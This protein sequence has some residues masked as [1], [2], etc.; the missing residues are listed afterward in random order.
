[1]ND[2]SHRETVMVDDWMFLSG[3]TDS[4]AQVVINTRFLI[5]LGYREAKAL[6][7]ALQHTHGPFI[8]NGYHLT[9]DEVFA[10][11]EW[12]SAIIDDEYGDEANHARLPHFIGC[13]P[14]RLS[15]RFRTPMDQRQFT[16]TFQHSPSV[17]AVIHGTP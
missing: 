17:L 1:M 4:T 13:E 11:H 8:L 10:L 3:D 6:G 5:P 16:N 12:E 14:V 7:E 2:D 9:Y 15:L